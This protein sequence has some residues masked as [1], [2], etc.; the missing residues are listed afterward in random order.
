MSLSRR[1]VNLARAVSP[2]VGLIVGVTAILTL[3]IFLHHI[4]NY[5]F[6]FDDF[7]IVGESS[8]SAIRRILT[9]P[10]FAFYRP[11]V[12]LLLRSEWHL[13]RW[14][15]PAGYMAVAQVWH[16]ANASL[17]FVLLR[18][19]DRSRIAAMCGATLFWLSPWSAETYLWLGARFDLV[20]TFGVLSSLVAAL[21]V[22]REDRAGRCVVIGLLGISAAAAGMFSKESGLVAIVACPLLLLVRRPRS[23]KAAAW[24]EGA[25]L[26]VAV[27]YVMT[28]THLLPGLDTAYG[29]ASGLYSRATIIQNAG[30]Y[31]RALFTAPMPGVLPGQLPSR[32]IL[33]IAAGSAALTYAWIWWKLPRIAALATIAFG[34]AIA[35]VV[36][37]PMPIESSAAS[38]YAYLPGV[39]VGV[40]FAAGVDALGA[41]GSSPWTIGWLIAVV[42][43]TFG[44]A[45]TSVAHQADTWRQAALLSRAT[46][47]QFTP[48]LDQHHE[49]VYISNLPFWFTDGPYVIK[50][51]AFSWYFVG[52]PVPM[53]R[54]RTMVVANNRGRLQFA[55][56][57]EGSQPVPATDE[58]VVTLKLPIESQ[59]SSTIALAPKQISLFT[60]VG[61]S[62]EPAEERISLTVDPG[63]PWHV[64]SSSP[65]FD[66]T[67]TTGIGPTTLRLIAKAITVPA[68]ERVAV[69]FTVDNSD[70]PATML[71][72]RFKSLLVTSGAPYGWVDLPAEPVRIGRAG[73]TFQGWALDNLALRRIWAEYTDSTGR[74][75]RVG[76][77]VR[78]GMRPDVAAAHPDAYDIF[79]AA[80]ALTV[81]PDAL[82]LP[83]TVVLRFYAENRSGQKTEIGS[84]TLVPSQDR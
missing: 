46:V 31:V 2:A 51:Y 75:V 5:F 80:W 60:L 30:S 9:F 33:S 6:L 69:S 79:N 45:G 44:Y 12:F 49:K 22:A 81:A 1:E 14:Q 18:Q 42:S 39:W 23:W 50:D 7:A 21:A 36:W 26:S 63:T 25:L 66:V 4:S 76:E 57:A 84:R 43:A 10:I 78:Q 56:W 29:G 27:A 3:W 37:Q 55:G 74:V 62:T 11:L 52:R 47:R 32:T 28:R 35:P 8:S 54:A 24:Y 64:D 67:P 48:I 13:F 77:A 61:T 20:A 40:L 65:R 38:R 41:A 17:L 72:V 53:I 58:F 68:D 15:H 73:I 16:I 70:V 82:H 71:T 59:P 19:L 34:L 83:S